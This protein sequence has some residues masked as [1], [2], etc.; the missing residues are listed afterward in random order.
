MENFKAYPNDQYGSGIELDKYNGEFS[1][2]NA[3]EKDG[4]VFKEWAFP[5]RYDKQAGCNKPIEK[6]LPWKIKLGSS[7]TEAIET[8]QF[9]IELLRGESPTDDGRQIPDD[10][11]PF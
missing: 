8:L 6:S 2:V 4:K 11:I 7:E 1:L 10:S 5:A 9:F 3:R